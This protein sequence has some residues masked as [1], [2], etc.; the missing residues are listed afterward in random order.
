[1]P[2]LNIIS[3]D[4]PDPPDYGG[5][6][7]IFHKVRSL[8]ATGVEVH[9]HCFTYGRSMTAALEAMCTSVHTYPRRVGWLSQWSSL[10]Y[11]V[12][13]RRSD[14]LV[15]NL[16]T[17]DFPILCEGLHC[18]YPLL[19]DNFAH[20][21]V[22]LRSHNVEH[23]YYRYL[24]RRERNVVRKLFFAKEAYLLRRLLGRLPGWLPVAAISPADS[25]TLQTKFPN[26]FW[27]PP[28]HA[29]DTVLSRE[30]FGEYA[31]YHGN[32][33]VS[34]NSEIA[35]R[36]VDRFDGKNIPLI[37]AGK[38][39]DG[40]LR[41]RISLSANV[42]LLADP[43]QPQ[44]AELIANAHVIL[45]LTDQPTGIKLKLI[46]SLYRGRFCVANASMVEGTGLEA[47]VVPANTDV[48]ATTAALLDRAFDHAAIEQRRSVMRA[49]YD[50]HRN[51]LLL[52]GKLGL[53]PEHEPSDPVG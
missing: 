28:F 45:L 51:A 10:P 19:R 8:Q 11:I 42:R 30:G 27:L 9:L 52:L 31:L 23:D 5:I 1:M 17:N 47:L 41:K 15:A 14:R 49:H 12:Y 3:L 18:V 44:M 43:E 35:H 24:A 25:R 53:S 22:M 48:Y 4:V 20:R 37:I 21:T 50:N 16:R 6:I 2:A 39:P 7:D 29:N 13:S 34:E 26:T 36:L 32:L 46:E 38:R 40:R 33:S